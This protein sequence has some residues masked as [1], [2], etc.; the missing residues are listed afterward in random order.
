M[1][2][3]TTSPPKDGTRIVAV[4]SVIWSDEFSTTVEPFATNVYWTKTECGYEGWRFSPS[5]Q[6]VARTFYD[7]VKIDSWLEYPAEVSSGQKMCACR[8]C[9]I[10]N[11]E[12]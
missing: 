1:S 6:A 3:K 2:W 5:D 8:A 7:E 12:R 10:V 4:G 9:K 11:P